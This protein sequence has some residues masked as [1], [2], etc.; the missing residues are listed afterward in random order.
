[1]NL[2]FSFIIITL[3]IF[4]RSHVMPNVYPL[5]NV[6]TFV[7]ICSNIFTFFCIFSV[8]HRILYLRM[9]RIWENSKCL[10]FSWLSYITLWCLNTFT[11]FTF[12]KNHTFTKVYVLPFLTV[13]SSLGLLI[14]CKF[15]EWK[16]FAKLLVG[17]PALLKLHKI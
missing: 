7:A 4:M 6:I 1:M 2:N 16:R 15:E 8:L 12:S 10:K 17:K 11:H 13:S 9:C 14:V 5:Q 3:V